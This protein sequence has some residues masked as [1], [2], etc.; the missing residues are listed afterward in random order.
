MF[1]KST[2]NSEKNKKFGKDLDFSYWY[3]HIKL[4]AILETIEFTMVDASSSLSVI[5]YTWGDKI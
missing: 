2:Q 5:L 4:A 1:I 3:I